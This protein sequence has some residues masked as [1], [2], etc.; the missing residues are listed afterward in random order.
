MCLTAVCVLDCVFL[1]IFVYVFAG[2]FSVVLSGFVCSFQ[3]QTTHQVCDSLYLYLQQKMATDQ[4]FTWT[5]KTAT[6]QK[7]ETILKHRT[8][9]T[10]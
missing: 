6:H 4:L 3:V 7:C 9:D 1:C 2:Y 5:R 8:G 10:L